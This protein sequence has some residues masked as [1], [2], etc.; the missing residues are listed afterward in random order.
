MTTPPPAPGDSRP[1]SR[2]R[3]FLL[4][5]LLG[6]LLHPPRLDG[7]I[8]PQD[9]GIWLALAQAVHEGKTLYRDVALHFGP[10]PLLA[11]LP[12]AGDG[13]TLSSV[14]TAFWLLN[15]LGLFLLFGALARHAR[16]PGPAVGTALC[17]GLVPFAAHTLTIP[18]A[19]R[20]GAGFLP[21]LFWTGDRPRAPWLAGAAAA[22]AFW[23]SQEA[24][25]AASAA[26]LLFF[27][28][29]GGPRAAG[30]FLAALAAGVGG[31]FALLA[32][33]GLLSDYFSSSV[34]DIGGLVFHLR[35]PLPPLWNAGSWA[36]LAEAVA[37]RL[38]ALL[39]LAV[40][41]AA[42]SPRLRRDPAAPRLSA[43]ALFTL[44][45]ASSALARSDRWH[46]YFSLSSGLFLAHLLADRWDAG[47]A[48]PWAAAALLAGAGFL[49]APH[50]W[51]ALRR[52]NLWR[53]SLVSCAAPRA[54]RSRLPAAQAA[55]YEILAEWASAHTRPGEPIFYYPFNGAAYFMVDRPNP[56]RLPLPVDAAR[57]DQRLAMVAELERS[58]TRWVL[59][60]GQITHYDGVPIDERLDPLWPR[61]RGA[62]HRA[63]TLGPW[64]LWER[65]D[66]AP[67]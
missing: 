55:G 9:D 4:F 8:N 64:E 10:L 6:A 52:E 66:P 37:A 50:A 24:G 20:Y 2:L 39:A 18:Y 15:L 17:L 43:A 53:G 35:R 48:R 60:D 44:L 16:R 59:R 12:V 36:G 63:A 29:T 23:I 65:N 45:A 54:G 41:G 46:I 33:R 49:T 30:R 1:F 32:G 56:C 57:E 14:R 28:W 51:S 34:A 11:L 13:M 5:C 67:R 61:I 47:R 31:G 7:P 22:A 40:L 27:A 19:A 38:P 62:F 42:A 21:I 58:D 25:T 26:T 3:L